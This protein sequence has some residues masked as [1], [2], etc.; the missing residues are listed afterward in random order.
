M[1][2]TFG[3]YIRVHAH[4]SENGEKMVRQCKTKSKPSQNKIGTFHQ[5]WKLLNLVS[6]DLLVLDKVR[7]G[8][9]SLR[10]NNNWKTLRGHGK[11]KQV[12]A[13]PTYKMAATT[14][15]QNIS[16]ITHPEFLW[17]GTIK[18]H[19]LPYAGLKMTGETVWE[20]MGW[21]KLLNQWL[22]RE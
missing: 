7:I 20:S 10:L 1:R 8:A 12:I 13:N 15:Y 16:S 6:L 11:I 17:R 3:N 21:H 5:Q 14:W 9:S 2:K 4:N 19:Y 18:E 22:P